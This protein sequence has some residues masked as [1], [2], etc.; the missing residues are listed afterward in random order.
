MLSTLGI[1]AA[2]AFMA[3]A[4]C[5]GQLK[6]ILLQKNILDVPNA[7]S[8]HTSPTPRGGGLAVISCFLAAALALKLLQPA[9][10]YPGMLFFAGLMLVTAAGFLDDRF[11]LPVILR[12]G[13]QTV[14]AALVIHET[15]GLASFPLPEPLSFQLGLFGLP[16]SLF[17]VLAVMN[18]YNFL[19][20]IDGFATVQALIA[21]CGMMLVD[22]QGPGFYMGALIFTVSCGFLCFNWH[23]ASIFLGDSG[24]LSLGFIF[25]CLPFYFQSHAAEAGIY[26]MICLLWL[27]LSDGS[28]VIVSRLLRGERIWVAHRSHFYQRLVIAGLRHDQVVARLSCLQLIN[29]ALLL[30]LYLFLYRLFY[31]SIAQLALLFMI[32]AGYVVWREKK[33]RQDQ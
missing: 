3:A 23:P 4:A 2:L 10:P 8:S 20:G 27:F 14:A 13:V 29:L 24:S 18:I 25:A 19:D 7:R 16:L 21:A 30:C 33:K 28:F 31:L 5:T 32:Y 11:S 26:F 15:G 22:F 17:W 1:V 6:K 12:F 9:I